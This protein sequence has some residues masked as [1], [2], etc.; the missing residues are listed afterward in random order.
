M[1]SKAGWQLRRI[2]WHPLLC[3]LEP[4]SGGGRGPEV[5]L[6][7]GWK[8]ATRG[9][10]FT[11]STKK[12]LSQGLL[13]LANGLQGVLWYCQR[14]LWYCQGGLLANGLQGVLWYCQRVLS[15]CQVLLLA[16]GLQGV[17]WYYQEP[18]IGVPLGVTVEEQLLAFFP[19]A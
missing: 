1:L 9:L 4:S 17:L 2:C 5:Q 3:L 7:K 13:L 10:W 16:N 11:R 8:R 19:G 6:V 18:V 14:V 15:Y 12:G